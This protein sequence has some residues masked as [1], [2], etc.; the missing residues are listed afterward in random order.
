MNIPATEQEKVPKELPPNF[1]LQLLDVCRET[2]GKTGGQIVLLVHGRQW[3]T[4]QAQKKIRSEILFHRPDRS[5]GYS[6]K[7]LIDTFDKIKQIPSLSL[8]ELFLRDGSYIRTP[9]KEFNAK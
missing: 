7:L 2:G 8:D 6:A 4:V 9:T 5:K 1:R 3:G